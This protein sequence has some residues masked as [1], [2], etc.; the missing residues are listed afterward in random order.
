MSMKHGLDELNVNCMLP[1]NVSL[2]SPHVIISTEQHFLKLSL[3][4]T[5]R[6]VSRSNYIKSENISIISLERGS[7]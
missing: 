2:N 3:K 1:L 5:I 7:F 4:F 6:Q